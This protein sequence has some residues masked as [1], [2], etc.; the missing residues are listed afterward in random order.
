MATTTLLLNGFS[1]IGDPQTTNSNASGG[2][3]LMIHN[4]TAIWED[5]DIIVFT[6]ENANEDGTLGDTSYIS[7][8]TVYDNAADYFN[9]VAKY[10]YTGSADI[11]T[12][13]NS[14]GDGY[15]QLDASGLTST[16]AG[17]PALGEVAMVPGVNILDTLATQNGPLEVNTIEDIDA[18]GDGTIDPDETG[19]GILDVDIINDVISI[20][21]ARGTLIETPDGPRFIE[22]LREGDLVNTLD[23]GPQP[24]RWIGSE[25]LDGRG[26]NAPIRIARGALG[27][28]RDLWVSPNHRML[29]R[30]P[31]A[32]L[33][34]GH[35]EVLV[36]AKHLVDG[37]R[38]RTEPRAVVDYFHFLCDEHQIVFAEG[39]ASESLFPGAQTLAT[40][41]PQARD[42]IVAYFPEIAEHDTGGDLSRYE[43]KK[44]EARALRAIA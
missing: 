28:I 22:T 2:G 23:H 30:G 33:L 13:R 24:I 36:A 12:G 3:E 15:L 39:C 26:R 14:M 35:D 16:D 40:V 6:I 9:D 18:D 7:G 19:D 42:E 38:I 25:R 34:F 8:I 20:C 43:L 27:N 32:E 41:Q 29:V 11:D 1:I 21:F 4:G 31:E 5:D 44:F 10:T 17:A 37:D